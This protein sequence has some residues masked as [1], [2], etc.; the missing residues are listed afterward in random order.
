MSR[1]A[2]TVFVA[3]AAADTVLAG[4]GRDRPRW[5]TKPLLMPA[6]MAASDRSSRRAL[7]RYAQ[8][9][10]CAS[11]AAARSATGPTGTSTI[12]N[13]RRRYSVSWRRSNT[14]DSS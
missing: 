2:T 9:R 3:L 5:L 14:S 13:P 11:I 4:M 10:M 12:S 1:R 8:D 6:L 7:A